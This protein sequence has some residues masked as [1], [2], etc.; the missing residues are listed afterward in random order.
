MTAHEKFDSCI[1]L[2]EFGAARHDGRRE[3]EWKVTLGLWGAI[4]A[5]IATVRGQPLPGWVGYATVLAFSFLW[6]RGIWVA[7]EKDK[8]LS[9]HYREQAEAVLRE[10]G[11]KVAEFK[12]ALPWYK[13]LFGFLLDWSMVFQ[14]ATTAGLVLLAYAFIK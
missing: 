9:I 12:L 10:D 4:V 14:I 1:K 5:G 7:N 2:A 11:Q 13:Q 6:L 8:R 3:Y